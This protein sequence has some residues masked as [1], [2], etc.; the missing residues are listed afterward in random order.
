VKFISSKD[1]FFILSKKEQVIDKGV[2]PLA[3][4]EA[5]GKQRSDIHRL[6]GKKNEL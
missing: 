6:P 2:T 3:K 1:K 5:L 4:L